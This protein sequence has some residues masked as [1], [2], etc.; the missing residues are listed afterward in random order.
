MTYSNHHHS[1]ALKP[2]GIFDSGIGGLTVAHALVKQLSKENI[3]YFGDT[4]HLPY[5]DKST[6]AIQAYSVKI[7]HLLLEQECKLILIACNSASSAAYELV[8]EYVGSKAIVLNVIDPVVATLKENYAGKQI[9]LIGT[10]QTVASNIFKKKIADLNV[11]I[12]LFANETNLLASAI[13]EFGNHSIIDELLKIYLAHPNLQQIDALILACTHYPI[14]KERISNYF[15]N[16]TEIIDPSTIVAKAVKNQLEKNNLLNATGSGNKHFY[17]S[18]YTTSF[19]NNA[20]LF[21]DC[22]LK[23]EHYPLWD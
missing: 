13:E 1:A 10:R 21:F 16:S 15:K 3:I 19:A 5:G 17:V 14:I 9:G 20:K 7:A 8:K 2:I 11:G 4:A 18:D 6:A 23:L 12:N 22:D